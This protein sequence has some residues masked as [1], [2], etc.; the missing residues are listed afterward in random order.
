MDKNRFDIVVRNKHTREIHHK[1]Y[2]LTEL[3]MGIN[4]LFDIENYETVSNRQFTG[5]KDKNGVD[6]YEGDIVY[7]AGTGNCEVKFDICGYWSF[8]EETFDY[9]D[10]I[11]DIENIVGNI[12]E[13]PEILEGE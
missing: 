7:I 10:V 3:M 9:Q 12:H 13:N 4:K 2:H 5:L 11:E 6:I 1:K 8:G